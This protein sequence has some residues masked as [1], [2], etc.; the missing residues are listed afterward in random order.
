[1]A[2]CGLTLHASSNVRVCA[3]V[4]VGIGVHVGIGVRVCACVCAGIHACVGIGVRVRMC[5]H[6]RRAY[7][8][9]CLIVF[10]LFVRFKVEGKEVV[11]VIMP[12]LMV[13]KHD[14]PYYVLEITAETPA[15][16]I[17]VRI[18]W[19]ERELNSALTDAEMNDLLRSDFDH[20]LPLNII[21]SCTRV[22]LL[23]ELLG[24]L[25][26]AFE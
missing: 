15:S 4:C 7:F 19:G 25:A 9:N 10:A 18:C 8:A 14:K 12:E 6:E 1:M 2:V 11:L 5:I 26:I 3:G 20:L 24:Q 13:T 17:L 23:W 22:D 16:D 21:N